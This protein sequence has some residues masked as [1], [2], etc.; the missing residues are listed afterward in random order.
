M[1]FANPVRFSF[2]HLE[3]AVTFDAAKGAGRG[4]GQNAFA[5]E[6]LDHQPR[7][8]LKLGRRDDIHGIVSA[9]ETLEADRIDLFRPLGRVVGAANDG[10]LQ[11]AVG[12]S[13]ARCCMRAAS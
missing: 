11:R 6:G 8:N 5:D 7:Q 1:I 10:E 12:Q 13:M 4:N 9:Y 2:N 3:E